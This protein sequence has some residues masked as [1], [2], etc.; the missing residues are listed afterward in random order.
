MPG[1][2]VLAQHPCPFCSRRCRSEWNLVRHVWQKHTWK[3]LGGQSKRAYSKRAERQ[4]D[5]RFV[6]DTL[7]GNRFLLEV[8]GWKGRTRHG[9][10]TAIDMIDCFC[11]QRWRY[12]A[13]SRT[14]AT[15]GWL[16]H[17]AEKGGMAAHILEL[18]LAT[19]GVGVGV[20]EL[21]LLDLTP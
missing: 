8:V 10:S 1:P 16:D 11:D 20:A 9:I 17:L 4:G 2:N 13:L 6:W 15:A 5:S 7:A 19:D 14:T 3:R 12:D 21:E 18:C